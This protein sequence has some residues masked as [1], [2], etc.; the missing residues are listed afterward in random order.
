MKQLSSF[1]GYLVL[2]AIIIIAI[3]GA[4]W[5]QDYLSYQNQPAEE[6]NNFLTYV[7]RGLTEELWLRYEQQIAELLAS[8]DSQG[9]EPNLNDLLLLGNAYNS[10]GQLAKAKEA[11]GQILMR[12][13]QDT[14]A[15]ENLGSTL[16]LM[17][18]YYGAE[19]AWLTAAEI[20][21]SEPHILK[22]VDLINNHIPEHKAQVKD[23]LELAIDQLGQTP[24]FL[25]TLGE[26][27]Y[28][29]GE[30]DRAVSHYRVALQIDPDNEVLATRLEEI[31]I[32]SNNAK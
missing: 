18:D 27:Y 11:Y 5:F 17:E 28:E 30:F 31:R 24:G 29:Q 1:R 8:I 15:L 13:P 7:D 14:P 2:A 16:Y 25:A 26:W 32:A 9:D 19:E 22:L 6:E 21:G 20:S 3:V 23:I 4:F 10:T 12:A